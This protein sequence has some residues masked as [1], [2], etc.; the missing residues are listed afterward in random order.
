M[1]PDGHSLNRSKFKMIFQPAKKPRDLVM[2]DKNH[3]KNF[4]WL[5]NAPSKMHEAP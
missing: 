5:K 1:Q 3:L 2:P 4:S